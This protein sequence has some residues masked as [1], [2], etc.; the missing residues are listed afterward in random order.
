MA[1]QDDR[2]IAPASAS[3][4][5]ETYMLK[6]ASLI[7]AGLSALV[8]SVGIVS[9]AS[10]ETCRQRADICKA[11]SN[12]PATVPLCYDKARLAQCEASG[13]YT[14]PSGRSFPATVRGR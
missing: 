4:Q 8:M 2:L 5:E 10:A 1:A 14:A 9:T 3:N 12:N 13:M 7:A 11:R 6:K